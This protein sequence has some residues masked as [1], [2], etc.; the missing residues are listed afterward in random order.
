MVGNILYIYMYIYV[1][2]LKHIKGIINHFFEIT[3]LWITQ[4]LQFLS[5]HQPYPEIVLE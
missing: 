1:C 2:K 5:H 4:V 3:C